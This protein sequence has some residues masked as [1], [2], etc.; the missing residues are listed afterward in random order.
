MVKG[1]PDNIEE[2]KKMA[3]NQNSWR[4]RLDAV[5]QLQNYDCPQSR[6]ILTRLAIHDIVFKVKEAAF[7][8]CQVLKVTKNGQP[9]RL[10]KKKQGKLIPDINKKL[11]KVRDTLP[12]GFKFEEFKI[13]FKKRYPAAY[14][15]YEGDKEKQFDKWLGNVISSLPKKKG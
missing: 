4:E 7:R 10:Q 14:D 6:D 15:A 12:E 2:L 1:T 9:I 5:H 8:A 13:E 3:N 11:T